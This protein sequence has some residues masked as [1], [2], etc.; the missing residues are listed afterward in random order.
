MVIKTVHKKLTFHSLRY[1]LIVGAIFLLSACQQ[2]SSHNK[3][4]KKTEEPENVIELVEIP[5]PGEVSIKDS[6]RIAGE[7]ERWWKSSVENTVFNG[8][9]LVAWKG[10]TIFERYHGSEPLG[11]DSMGPHKALHIASVTKTFTAMA[12]LKLAEEGKLNI[13]DL[14]SKYFP[15]FNYDSVTIRSLLTHRSGLPNYLY[16]TEKLGLDPTKFLTNERLYKILIGNK[17]D[18]EGIEPPN[19]R[20]VYNNTNYALLALLIEKVSGLPYPQFMKNSIFIP[21]GLKDTYVYTEFDS[22]KASRNYDWRG[23]IEPDTY[24]DGIY[25]DKNIYS[26]CRDLLIWDRVLTHNL[27]LKKETIEEAYHP[28]SNEKPGVKNYGLGWRMNIMDNGKKFIFHTGWWHGNTALFARLLDEDATI[29]M[30]SNRFTRIPYQ[31]KWLANTFGD[32]FDPPPAIADT[33]QLRKDS[34]AL[35]DSLPAK[36]KKKRTERDEDAALE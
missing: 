5:A 31:S 22:A 27:Y 8:G 19:R 16:A 20:F 24:L 29:I 32:Y 2:G 36:N 34:L 6:I 33:A 35:K 30:M 1:L 26:T 10:K 13:D 15:D 4:D 21:F 14:F 28:Y 23:R 9:V 11:Q 3:K 25:G 18:L 17:A 12:V 7:C